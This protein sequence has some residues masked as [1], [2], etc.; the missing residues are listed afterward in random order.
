MI[1]FRLI[2]EHTILFAEQFFDNPSDLTQHSRFQK[3]TD[4][5]P[6]EIQAFV[7]LQIATGLN[8]KPSV[9]DYWR[10]YWLTE[11]K[12]GSVM[13]WNRYL[14]LST[15][16][17]FSNNEQVV[18]WGEEDF[19]LLFKIQ[20]VLDIINPVYENVYG[21]GKNLCIDESMIKFKGRIYFRQYLPAKPTTLGNKVFVLSESDSG[22]GLK[23]E[24]Y[25]GKESFA[26]D[27]ESLFLN[28][29][30]SGCFVITGQLW[31]QR[32]CRIHG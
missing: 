16:L 11:T 6:N 7:A 1:F 23:F 2:S 9:K 8:C 27:K 26:R 13:S 21:P 20:P 5:S 30:P 28:S 18:Q 31:K 32:T 14:L 17:H 22:Y 25:T 12:F 3:W 15:C 29:F 24:V 19:N 4:T 10:K